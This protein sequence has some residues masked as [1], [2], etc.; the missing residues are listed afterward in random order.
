MKK[1][2][3]NDELFVLVL[4][5]MIKFEFDNC[6]CWLVLVVC[7]LECFSSSL[8]VVMVSDVCVGSCF[9]VGGRII[10]I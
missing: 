5:L 2:S 1:V 10:V 6:R 3:V 4:M 7:L 8:W 9:L